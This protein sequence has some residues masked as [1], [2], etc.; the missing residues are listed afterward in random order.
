[1]VKISDLIQENIYKKDTTVS[2]SESFSS[3]KVDDFLG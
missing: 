2:Y 3:E 1:M